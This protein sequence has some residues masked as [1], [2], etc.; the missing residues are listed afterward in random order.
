MKIKVVDTPDE[1]FEYTS[2][3]VP[4]KD[5]L[6]YHKNQG[7]TVSYVCHNVP[8]MSDSDKAEEVYVVIEVS[9]TR[10]FLGQQLKSY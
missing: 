8:D 9:E 3:I 7:Y 5:E 1:L 6:I 10:S 2:D 4:R